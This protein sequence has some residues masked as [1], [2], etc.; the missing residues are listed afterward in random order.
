MS[1]AAQII[2]DG[3]AEVLALHRTGEPLLDG[4]G[5]G[6]FTGGRQDP[7]H[8][9]IGDRL[10]NLLGAFRERLGEPIGVEVLT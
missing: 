1:R 6:A 10:D 4:L 9:L 7:G 3:P 8:R 5:Y 2:V